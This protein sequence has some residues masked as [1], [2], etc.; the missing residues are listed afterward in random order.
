[1]KLRHETIVLVADG[2]R[3]LLLR[4]QGDAV[5]PDLRVIEH[6]ER[7][8]PANRKLRSDAPGVAHSMGHPGRSTMDDGDPHQDS[9]DRFI[10]EAADALARVAAE[11]HNGIVVV[12]PPAALGALRRHY[13]PVLADRLI[14]EIDKDL[15]RHPVDAI[16]DLLVA[17][18]VREGA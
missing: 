14:A 1:M 16:A 10:A 7:E 4:N 2:S 3:M 13:H 9:E 15:T 6:R 12:A 5:Y 17:H 11:G 8:N 18:T